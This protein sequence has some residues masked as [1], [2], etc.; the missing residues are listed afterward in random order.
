[1]RTDLAVVV[2]VWQQV[3]K[4]V[5]VLADQNQHEVLHITYST[6][7]RR[8]GVHREEGEGDGKQIRRSPACCSGT[9]SM[10]NA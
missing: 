5:V 1:M 9:Q 7:I 10:R 3:G 4:L 8:A 2:V 6:E